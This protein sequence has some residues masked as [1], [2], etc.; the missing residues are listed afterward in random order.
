MPFDDP[1]LFPGF[2]FFRVMLFHDVEI[3]SEFIGSFLG[4]IEDLLNVQKGSNLTSFAWW[5]QLTVL[6]TGFKAN[7]HTPIYSRLH[8]VPF[9]G[10]R[11]HM[12]IE[13]Y[14]HL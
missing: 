4:G 3:P 13:L 2:A 12:N 6:S 5:H 11:Q 10:Q 1:L 8:H 7:L 14:I 9:H